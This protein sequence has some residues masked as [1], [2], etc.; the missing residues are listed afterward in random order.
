M[1]KTKRQAIVMMTDTQR[2]DMLGCYGHPDMK[3]PA[4]DGLA[5]GGIRFEHAYTC[6]PVCGPARSAL[7]TGLFPHSN[8]SW[9][10]C[11]PLGANV[12]TVGQRLRDQGILTGYI[13]KWHLDG[14]D[15]FGT[16]RCPD[17]WDPATW[18]D[19]RNY[20][21][22]LSDADRLRSRK[23]RTNAEGIDPEFTFG[24][25]CANRAIEFIK[26]HADEDFLLILSFD[27][28]HGPCL[29]PEPF[30][31]MYKG[32][33]FPR[34]EAVYDDLAG[35]PA[36]QRVWADVRG[37]KSRAEREALPL[38]GAD[39]LGCNSFAD[40]EIGR[41][42][43]Q[44]DRAI[45]GS[46]VVYTT[47][48]GDLL[49]SHAMWNKGPCTYEPVANIP[50]LVRWAGQAPSGA[51]CRHPVSHIDL[52]P[53]LLDYFG[54]ERPPLLEGISL[55]PCFKEPDR[56]LQDEVFVEFSR[57]ETDHDGFGG[58]Q[59]LRC[60][61]DGRYK[62][63]VNLLTTDELY[64]LEADP[65]EL[66]NRIDSPELAAVRDRL[67]DRLIDWM[68]RTRDP[69]RGYYWLNRPWRKDAPAPTWDFT[70]MTR[71]REELPRYEDRQLDYG[72]GLPMRVATRKKGE[73]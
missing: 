48:H 10:N 19:M 41:V 46:L 2:K 11:M 4:L 16:G 60:V 55:L 21:E 70:L 62:L 40:S 5:A 49:G 13:G 15:Y 54:A 30:A 57:Y 42:L 12:L 22:E 67:H 3:T 27:E 33:A 26:R 66:K 43:E 32:Y 7:F 23:T 71:Q 69:F 59:P 9:S 47:D 34:T 6:Q 28:P 17:G 53:T 58:F 8:G 45:P 65:E 24:R 68:N 61:C 73:S 14:G 18:Y 35:K 39:Y 63:T 56:K 20:L 29:C 52:T 31:S 25:R 72:T 38:T 37:N 50:F 51:V 64:D 36:H 1:M 44:V